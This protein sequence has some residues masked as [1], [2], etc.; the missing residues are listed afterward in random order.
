MLLAKHLIAGT[1]MLCL[2]STAYGQGSISGQIL[3]VKKQP[4][5]G[6]NIM[7]KGTQSGTSSG[8]DGRFVLPNLAAGRYILEISYLGYQSFS[9]EVQVGKE[10]VSLRIELTPKSATFDELI[11][12]ATRAGA[13]T[14]MTVTNISKEELEVR[15]LGQDLPFLL[16]YTPSVVAT[17]DAGTGIGY[18]G[19]RIRGTD[20]TRINVTIN[21]I[22]L[23][24]AE[25]QGV[26][27][28]NMP[29]FASSTDDIQIQRGVGTSTNGAGAFGAT[30][31]L[32]TSKLKP[33]PYARLSGSVGSFNTWKG[34][35]QFGTGLLLDQFTIDGR[36]SRITSDGF[37]DRATAD[38]SSYYLSGA[39]TGK[40]S[41]L[42]FITFSGQEVTY[43]AWY[44]V[45]S[46]SLATNR[47]YNPA[48]TQKPGEPYD[49][50]VDDY[51]Q[52][53]YQVLFSQEIATEWFLNLALHY[54]QGAGFFEQY[55]AGVPFVNYGLDPV[56]IGG[57]TISQTDLVQR[58]WLDN[59][60]YGGTYSLAWKPNSIVSDLTM[61]GGYHVYEG[62]HFGELIWAQFTPQAEKD[63]RFYE[64]D[65]RKTDFNIFG[66][67]TIN[68]LPSL[69]GYLDLQYRRVTYQFL[70][71]DNDLSPVNQE[72]ELNFFNPKVGL[73][74]DLDA[75][76]EIYASFAVAQREPNRADFISSPPQNRPVAEKLYDTEAGFRLNGLRALFEAT[77]YFMYYRDQLALSG[78]VNE[79][80]AFIRENIDQ[81][82]RLGLELVA[83]WSPVNSFRIEGNATF[84]QNRVLAFTEFVDQFDEDFNFIGQEPVEYENTN[85]SFSPPIISG[86]TLEWM[87]IREV[88]SLKHNLSTTLF[89][90][91][92]G[93]QFVDNTSDENNTLDPYFFSD[94]Q[95][96]Y[97][98]SPSWMKGIEFNLLIRNLWN[99]EFETNA[100]S[101]RYRFGETL[102]VDQSLF[103]QAGINVL[104]GLTL[105]F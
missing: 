6:A 36:L 94:L 96:R 65:A 82:Y 79:V 18:T 1:A 26:F 47:T 73:L 45:P 89:N 29:D 74:Y 4:M 27:W 23:N 32:N 51:R 67:A 93:K 86:I 69:Y 76:K 95:F 12:S 16:R 22:P 44:G 8:A 84:S 42:R 25:S 100:Y 59:D 83:G 50:E 2:L 58:L 56:F 85:L 57:D 92:V 40:K 60:F 35:V 105:D 10:D 19:I 20:P 37:I 28:V 103:P 99:A 24:D 46:D 66:K 39:W 62:L 70:G 68:L 34:N 55:I 61:G 7:L 14:P 81:S 87:P 31:N 75:T 78:Q 63:F 88:G 41:Q 72:V 21:G 97:R 52:T 71:I 30:L 53:H 9:Q 104:F 54:T 3:S 101:Y 91:Y 90:K 17:S 43:Q 11:V 48:G 80:G 15:N 49:N 98:L 5:A 77:G 38:L 102:I 13:K 64:N 33:D